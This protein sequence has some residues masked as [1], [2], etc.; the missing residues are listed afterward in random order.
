[1]LAEPGRKGLLLKPG[2]VSAVLISAD[3]IAVLPKL[4]EGVRPIV[5]TLKFGL[6]DMEL[7]FAKNQDLWAT[8]F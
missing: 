3:A 4:A 1:L 7:A 2:E 8:H 5:E 6:T